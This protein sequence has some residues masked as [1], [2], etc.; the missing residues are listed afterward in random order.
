MFFSITPNPPTPPPGNSARTQ[1]HLCLPRHL[2]DL[3]PSKN[4][5]FI[6]KKCNFKAF[7]VSVHS[8]FNFIFFLSP[9][10][11]NHNFSFVPQRPF[12]P[13]PHHHCILHDIYPWKILNIFY[14]RIDRMDYKKSCAVKNIYQGCAI[15]LVLMIAGCK[16]YEI[17][18]NIHPCAPERR[19][20]RGQFTLRPAGV[21]F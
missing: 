9:F 20:C 1:K 6:T 5:E 3:P 21:S 18:G 19:L 14:R 11:L 2:E 13:L 10:P 17:T 12:S 16:I 15:L 4:V 8:L 7:Y